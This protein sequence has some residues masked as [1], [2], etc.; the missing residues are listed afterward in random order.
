MKRVVGALGAILLGFV[1]LV[2][3]TLA[4][5]PMPQTGRVIVSTQGDVTLPAGEHADVVVVVVVSRGSTVR[6]TR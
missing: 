1:L 4:A 6:S 2:P 3:V 5:S